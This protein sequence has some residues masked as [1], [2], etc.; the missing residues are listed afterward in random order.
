MRKMLLIAAMLVAQQAV[1]MTSD[2]NFG[3]FPDFWADAQERVEQL[4]K[5]LKRVEADRPYSKAS[6]KAF[7]LSIGLCASKRKSIWAGGSGNGGV[8]SQMK[9]EAM[10]ICSRIGAL[11][12]DF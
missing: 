4:N 7:R 1:A 3:N 8:T 12:M 10:L 9:C 11:E 6:E 2:C 5:S